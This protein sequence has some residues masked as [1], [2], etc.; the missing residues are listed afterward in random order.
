MLGKMRLNQEQGFGM[1]R[2]Q[3]TGVHSVWHQI[4]QVFVQKF[5]VMSHWELRELRRICQQLQYFDIRKYLFRILKVNAEHL[6]SFIVEII[7]TGSVAD[8]SA[9][10][11][12]I[13]LLHTP[14]LL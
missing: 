1:R 9:L 14:C 8:L 13:F 6:D 10:Q 7:K 4:S 11:T 12:P 5:F 2:I 3:S